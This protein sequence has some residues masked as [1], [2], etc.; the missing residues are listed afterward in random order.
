MKSGRELNDRLAIEVMGWHKGR[1]GWWMHQGYKRTTWAHEEIMAGNPECGCSHPIW[2]PSEDIA[3]AWEVIEKMRDGVVDRFYMGEPGTD[4][5]A[6]FASFERG[7]EC[8]SDWLS[9]EASA[10]TMPHAIC[11]AALKAVE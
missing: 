7:H 10:N 9:V 8:G 2:R 11:L 1:T 5:T 3:A 6:F 4:G